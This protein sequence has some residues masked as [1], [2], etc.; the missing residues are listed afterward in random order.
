M[1][2]PNVFP[3]LSRACMSVSRSPGRLVF[4]M[5]DCASSMEPGRLGV[6]IEATPTLDFVAWVLARLVSL[7]PI[8]GLRT[9]A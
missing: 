3:W 4:F 7:C 9:Q 2:K 6:I 1:V 8:G 5:A